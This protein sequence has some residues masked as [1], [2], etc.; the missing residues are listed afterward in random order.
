MS[1]NTGID[2]IGHVQ[3]GSHFC[4]F[5]KTADDLSET[6]IP[7]FKTGL[8]ENDACVW[9]TAEPYEKARA[10]SELNT[11]VAHLERRIAAGQ[12]QVLGHDEWYALHGAKS[13]TDVAQVWIAAKDN[14]VSAGYRALRLTGNTAFLE[15]SDWDG[16]Y[17][18][19]TVLREAFARQKL[20]ALCSY[21]SRRC[22]ADIVLDVVHAHDFAL[23]RRKGSW[24]LV[25][26]ASL[27]Q[28]KAELVALNADLERLVAERT[29]DLTEALEHQ[30]FLTAELSHRVK[31]T[32][33]T[34]LTIADQTLK[35]AG[36]DALVRST[37]R[38]RLHT[39]ARAHEKLAAAEWSGVNLRELLS[40]IAAPYGDRIRMDM[41][42]EV[43]TPRATLDLGLLFHELATNAAKYGALSTAAGRVTVG[44]SSAGHDKST[45]EIV[46]REERGPAVSKPTGEGFGLM[47]VRRLIAHDLKGECELRFEPGGLICVIRA[48]AAELLAPRMGCG[49]VH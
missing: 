9:V 12:L 24:E 29:R 27:K 6:L 23:A 3:W 21:D 26:S 38:G 45:V 34:I 7:Y 8:E 37:L 33:A 28:A 11:H 49:H 10:L 31:N 42:G 17:E 39:L 35:R 4:H 2:P 20:V 22:D 30:R 1:V 36:V 25:E 15:R 41:N 16:F 48:P 46:W 47:L 32:V 14:A 44:V 43:L 40:V 5:Y 19:E 13:R 18:Y